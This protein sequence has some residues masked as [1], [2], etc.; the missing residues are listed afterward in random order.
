MDTK[1]H[2]EKVYKA[3][4]PDAV[5]W[6]QPHLETSLSLIERAARGPQTSIIDVGGGESTLADDL[7]SRGFENVTVLDISETAIDVC[8]KRLGAMA[9]RIHWLVADVT[10]AEL[11][12]SAY[13]IW[14]DRAVFH[15][16][17]GQEQRSAYVRNVAR[18]VKRDGHVIV[19]T[20]GPEG[21]MKCSGL[22]VV[23]YDADSLHDQFGARFRLLESSREL[24]RTP[25]G[26]IQ[27]F[28]YCYCKVDRRDAK[29]A[30]PLGVGPR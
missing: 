20:F 26:T 13:D 17:I 6:Y 11:N 22:D 15:F 18:S 27:Q 9:G 12:A 21:P 28:L 7:L 5:S 2:W 23:R 4:A 8:K 25:S 3:K 16:L 29:R 19:S 30:P 10:R 14:H 24:H 1:K